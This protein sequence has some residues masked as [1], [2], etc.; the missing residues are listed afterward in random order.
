MS[1]SGKNRIFFTA[2]DYIAFDPD[3]QRFAET[4]A[5]AMQNTANM[6]AGLANFHA[7]RV[8][9]VY[10]TLPPALLD[11]LI[12]GVSESL[13]A[14]AREW[15]FAAIAYKRHLE[16]VARTLNN[17]YGSDAVGYAATNGRRR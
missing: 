3:D 5:A 11:R 13:G 4:R 1:A 8:R 14:A 16:E 6:L 2:Y 17:T 10:G 7:E 15:E 12:R 9:E